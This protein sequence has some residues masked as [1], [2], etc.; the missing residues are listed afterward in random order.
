[1][2]P[3]ALVAEAAKPRDDGLAAFT[4]QIA[5]RVCESL[6]AFIHTDEHSKK[7]AEL[8]KWT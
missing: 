8:V 6:E 1:M 2:V 4:A 3:D 5:T 7:Y